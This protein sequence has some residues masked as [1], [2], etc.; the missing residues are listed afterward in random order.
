MISFIRWLCTKE[1]SPSCEADSLLNTTP[2]CYSYKTM[3]R[4]YIQG[5]FRFKLVGEI[6]DG[7]IKIE[8]YK[9]NQLVDVFNLTYNENP[10]ELRY[11]II[12]WYAD[13]YLIKT[14]SNTIFQRHKS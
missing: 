1:I 5:K 14:S 10:E 2:L 8:M 6:Q 11:N 9:Y 12:K 13:N 4:N 3:I 7:K